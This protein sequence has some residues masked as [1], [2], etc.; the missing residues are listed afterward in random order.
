MIINAN[1]GLGEVGIFQS[2]I[3]VV[4]WL[5]ASVILVLDGLVQF[6][7]E[8]SLLIFNSTMELFGCLLSDS[9]SIKPTRVELCMSWPMANSNILS[10]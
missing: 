8:I 7:E 6:W 2:M 5:S 10:C 4:S 3:A 9:N 1:Y